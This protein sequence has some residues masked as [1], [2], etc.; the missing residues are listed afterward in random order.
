MTILGHAGTIS[1]ENGGV[2]A[3]VACKQQVGGCA[4]PAPVP[5]T[6]TQIGSGYAFTWCNGV[7]TMGN[8]ANGGAA[9]SSCPRGY[10]IVGT[11][12]QK[13]YP[14]T[15]GTAAYCKR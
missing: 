15:A 3:D 5:A 8:A 11:M 1:D 2:T 4:L 9:V 6:G 12:C 13:S 10:A 14:A 7:F